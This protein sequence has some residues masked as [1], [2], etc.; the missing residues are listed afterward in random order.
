MQ[1]DNL[2]KPTKH[3]KYLNSSEPYKNP[4]IQIGQGV[5]FFIQR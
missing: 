1:N 2:D 4:K 3:S 5:I